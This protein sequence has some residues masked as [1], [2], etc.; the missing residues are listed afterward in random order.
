VQAVPGTVGFSTGSTSQTNNSS[1]ISA[2]VRDKDGNLVKNAAVSFT[3]TL[4][5]TGGRLTSSSGITDVSGTTSVTYVAGGTSSAQNGVQISATVNSVNGVA[6]TPVTGTT[7]LTVSGQSLLVRL[8]T[9]NKVTVTPAP[10]NANTKT[11]LAIVTDAGGNPVVGTTVQFALR[12]GRYQKGRFV[13]DATN[14]SWVPFVTATC[15]NEDLNFNGILDLVNGVPGT[16]EDLV[17]WPAGVTH[18]LRPGA[19]AS[20]NGTAVTDSSGVATATIT[21]AKN[22]SLWTEVTLEAR[23]SVTTNDPPTQTTFFLP[24]AAADYTPLSTA[25]PPIPWGSDNTCADTL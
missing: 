25:P 11:Y 17:T 13:A 10:Q 5:P 6:V 16:G 18:A 15:A 7:T 14:T 12:P 4:D 20:V 19:V 2:V 8:G 24:G 22:Y 23:T 9:D 3:I 1:T 21:Y